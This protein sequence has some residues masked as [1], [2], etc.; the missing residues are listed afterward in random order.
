MAKSFK[1]IESKLGR[2]K[3]WGMAHTDDNVIEIDARL[4][5]RKKMEIILHEAMH[6]LNPQFTEEEVIRQSKKLCLTLWNLHYRQVDND[7]SQPLQ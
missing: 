4:K 6:L 5:G 1:V 2:N 7:K 3:A